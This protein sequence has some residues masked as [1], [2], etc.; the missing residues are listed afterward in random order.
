MKNISHLICTVFFLLILL[1]NKTSFSQNINNNYRPST[2]SF[3]M[4]NRVLVESG[5]LKDG[6]YSY[7]S[8]GK[9]VKVEIKGDYYYEHHPNKE[10][11]KAK[12]DW[13]TEFKYKLTI[14][15]LQKS[16]VLLKVGSNLI[17]QIVEIKNN[18]YF[19]TCLF[20]NKTRK[21]SFKKTME[22]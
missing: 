6:E 10:Y 9:T 12:I 4:Y 8:N 3:S 22:L 1:N 15:D 7:Q 5:I 19:Y 18:E 13:I 2:R 14:V 17:S 20:K 11:I 21:G 16:N